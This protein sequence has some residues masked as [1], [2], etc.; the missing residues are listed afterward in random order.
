[1]VTYDQHGTRNKRKG[2]SKYDNTFS[3][4]VTSFEFAVFLLQKLTKRY[5]QTC[6]K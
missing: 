4:T 6:I 1:M 3:K 2:N 5:P